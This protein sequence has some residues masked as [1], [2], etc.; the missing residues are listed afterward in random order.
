[1]LAMS[2]VN[3]MSPYP[4]RVLPFLDERRPL[5]PLWPKQ[6]GPARSSLQRRNGTFH[7]AREG[8]HM[9]SHSLVMGV[10]FY[11]GVVLSTFVLGC[12]HVWWKMSMIVY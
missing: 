12:G 8:V 2:M 10:R 3:S 11:C 7:R 6:T 4:N 9:R 1:M 5:S